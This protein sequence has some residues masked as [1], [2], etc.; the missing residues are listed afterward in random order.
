MPL[1]QITAPTLLIHGTQD[2]D[3]PFD[4]GEF[5]AERIPGAQRHWMERDD[6]LGFWLSPAASQ[7]QAVARA[8]L[9]QHAPVE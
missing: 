1:E 3:V 7:V 2:G 4:H 9:R 5:A 8:F 6:H